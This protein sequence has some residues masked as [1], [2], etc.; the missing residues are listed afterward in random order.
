MVFTLKNYEFCL[1]SSEVKP[2]PPTVSKLLR[3]SDGD[4]FYFCN[5]LD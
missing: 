5:N 3:V 1:R 4:D 2:P